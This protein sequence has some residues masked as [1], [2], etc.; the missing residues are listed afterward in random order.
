MASKTIGHL[1]YTRSIFVHHFKAIGEFELELQSRQV[2]EYGLHDLTIAANY[3]STWKRSDLV[4]WILAP[5]ERRKERN[6]A[7]RRID[8][9]AVHETR[10]CGGVCKSQNRM[11]TSKDSRHA[12][13]WTSNQERKGDVGILLAECWVA[14][15][16]GVVRTSDRTNLLKLAIGKDINTIISVYAP[17]SNLPDADK[18]NF[19]DELRP[20]VLG[21]SWRW[22]S[23]MI[24]QRYSAPTDSDGMAM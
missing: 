9:C 18:D 17:Q 6:L 20:A 8:L 23:L 24:W 14:N 19:Y 16:F 2:L 5:S 10:W 13:F 7:R 22:C 11:L 3:T 1:F 4:K 21:I 15:V 12:F